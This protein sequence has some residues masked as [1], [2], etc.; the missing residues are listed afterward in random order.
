[1]IY[2]YD[3]FMQVGQWDNDSPAGR[4]CIGCVM[5]PLNQDRYVRS[6]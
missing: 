3:S 1:M 5:K 2:I 6:F 4:L